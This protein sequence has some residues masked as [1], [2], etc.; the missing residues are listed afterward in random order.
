MAV[1]AR[2]ENL[3]LTVGLNLRE[4]VEAGHFV[5]LAAESLI[6]V[7]RAPAATTSEYADAEPE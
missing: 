6:G 7:M 1:T 5:R 2:A 4:Y 3:N